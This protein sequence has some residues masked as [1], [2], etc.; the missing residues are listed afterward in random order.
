M[1]QEKSRLVYLQNTMEP[2]TQIRLFKLN[3]LK[4]RLKRR[5][6]NKKLS[7][8]NESL[9]IQYVMFKYTLRKDKLK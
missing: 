6:K 4:L 3:A 5:F 8:S 7:I 2:V 9:F 1:S